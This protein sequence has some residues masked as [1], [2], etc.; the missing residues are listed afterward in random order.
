MGKTEES[1]RRLIE[2]RNEFEKVLKEDSEDVTAH[3]NL[4]QVYERLGDSEAS[5]RHRKLHL[6]Y[7]PD[8]N[9]EAMAK[10]PARQRYPAANA[11]AEAI[12]IYDLR[13]PEAY[14]LKTAQVANR[15][16]RWWCKNPTPPLL[17]PREQT[18]NGLRRK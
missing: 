6:K 2:A 11:A 9:A 5:E 17:K 3:A 13:R 7:K 18:N 12:T 14:G 4:A 15:M 16:F 8:D 10:I 1:E